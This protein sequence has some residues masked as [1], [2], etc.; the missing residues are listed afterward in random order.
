MP[1]VAFDVPGLFRTEIHYLL[2]AA[3]D[4]HRRLE[5]WVH[6]LA[7][8][9]CAH[10]K[11]NSS[12][13]RCS[14]SPPSTLTP[15][16]KQEMGLLELESL[17][18]LYVSPSEAVSLPHKGKL[19]CHG[20]LQPQ[21]DTWSLRLCW[22]C[23]QATT[24]HMVSSLSHGQTPE[25]TSLFPDLRTHFIPFPRWGRDNMEEWPK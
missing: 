9:C 12:S 22:G 24:F 19:S 6:N 15:W 3:E 25:H 14:A 20:K 23:W 7:I 5:W 8:S 18:G 16:A 2:C 21:E 11:R 10:L 17:S 4:T 1:T 13:E